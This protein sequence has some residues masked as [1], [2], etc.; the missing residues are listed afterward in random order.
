MKTWLNVMMAAM[1]AALVSPPLMAGAPADSLSSARQLYAAAEYDDA[2]QMLSRLELG[3]D[4]AGAETLA[5]AQVRA[6]CLLALGRP[7]DAS[8]AISV[9]V[10]ADPMYRPAVEDAAPRVR[11]AFSEVRKRMLPAIIQQ[12]YGVAKAHFDAK[13]FVAA[14]AAF[15][16]VLDALA[17]PELADAATQPP[18]A[19]LRTLAGGFLDLSAAAAVPPPIASRQQPLA[20]FPITAASRIYSAADA[21]VSPPLAVRQPIPPFSPSDTPPR[22]GMLELILD[23]RGRVEDVLIRASVADRYDPMLLAAA[24][25]WVYAPA[26]LDGRPVKYRKMVQIAVQQK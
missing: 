1:V 17:D 3:E 16:F 12:R 25:G 2:L 4:G 9:I 20:M 13:E 21:A 14:R 11:A 23:E 7:D 6:Y 5:V 10:A 8:S 19:D 18:L 26:L 15:S 24:R 22:T